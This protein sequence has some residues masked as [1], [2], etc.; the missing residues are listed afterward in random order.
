MRPYFL[1]VISDWNSF[2]RYFKRHQ[3]FW[4]DG[5]SSYFMKQVA[6][7]ASC[8]LNDKGWKLLQAR[9]GTVLPHVL[10]PFAHIRMRSHP[11]TS[12]GARSPMLPHH[13]N[14]CQ[15]VTKPFQ[16]TLG[17]PV[18]IV[19]W[20][21]HRRGLGR[22]RHRELTFQNPVTGKEE[23]GDR[24]SVHRHFHSTPSELLTC[25]NLLLVSH[26]GNNIVTQWYASLCPP[27]PQHVVAITSTSMSFRLDLMHV[28][29]WMSDMINF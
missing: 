27:A 17:L 3:L 15:E 1:C 28:Y 8:V 14:P 11:L 2:L 24:R 4:P 6:C 20:N 9:V 23:S 26:G 12:L 5:S 16:G 18:I 21:V 10:G 19:I 22:M 7:V 13:T 25:L 29:S